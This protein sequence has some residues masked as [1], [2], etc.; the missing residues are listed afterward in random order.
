MWIVIKDE[1]NTWERNVKLN[2]DSPPNNGL[3]VK[4]VNEK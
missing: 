2:R 3:T 1:L 4:L